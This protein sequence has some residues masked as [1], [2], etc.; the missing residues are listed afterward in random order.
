M[1]EKDLKTFAK[2][3]KIRFKRGFWKNYNENKQAEL[4]RAKEKG[5]NEKEALQIQIERAKREIKTQFDEQ[6]LDDIFYEKVA[7]ILKSDE[8]ILNPI[9]RLIDHDVYDGLNDSEKQKYILDLTEK[10][11]EMKK[12]YEKERM[13]G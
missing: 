4:D 13:L 1:E 3:A 11:N 12:R 10:F 9:T 2:E 8:I 6:T 7:E 5:I